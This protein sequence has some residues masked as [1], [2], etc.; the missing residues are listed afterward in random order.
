MRPWPAAGSPT[1][2]KAWWKPTSPRAGSGAFSPTGARPIPAITCSTRAAGSLRRPSR[3]CS[4]R[5]ATAPDAENSPAP[6]QRVVSRLLIDRVGFAE[7]V[8]LVNLLGPILRVDLLDPDGN[9]FLA[10]VQRGH[11]DL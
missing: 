10:I 1:C 8:R 7:N 9:G 3:S 4:M 2:P 5:C 6:S 11:D